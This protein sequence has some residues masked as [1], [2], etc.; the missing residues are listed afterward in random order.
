MV[1]SMADVIDLVSASYM[2]TRLPLRTSRKVL[3]S[4]APVDDQS[5]LSQMCEQELAGMTLKSAHC[6]EALQLDASHVTCGFMQNNCRKLVCNFI[7][8]E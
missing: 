6:H 8:L 2:A 7:L 1:T 3:F 5:T 4:V